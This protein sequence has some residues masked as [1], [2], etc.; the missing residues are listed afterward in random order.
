[1][2][3]AQRDRADDG[4]GRESQPPAPGQGGDRDHHRAHQH[5]R[6]GVGETARQRQQN[7][8]LDDVIGKLQKGFPVLGEALGRHG[9]RQPGVDPGACCDH[10]ETR[11][12][13][14]VKAQPVEHHDH[15]ERLAGD[16]QPTQQD[17]RAQSDAA[18][19]GRQVRIGVK[20]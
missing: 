20:L 12:K 11:A 5:D 6:E 4:D 19:D 13:G 9:E 2:P 18:E 17:Q 10:G 16:R 3:D 15:G 8:Q 14:Q 1:M 7:H